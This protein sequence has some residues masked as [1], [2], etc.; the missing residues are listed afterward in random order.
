[1]TSVDSKP[2]AQ[3]LTEQVAMEFQAHQQ[4]IALAVWFDGHDL[5]QLGKLFYAQALE[6]R[7]HGMMM[8]QYQLDRDLPV[9]IPA[10]DGVRNEFGHVRELIQLALEQEKDV[11]AAI[12]RLFAAARAE[13]DYI[14]EQFV[15]WFLK[16]QVEEI[17]SMTTLLT[18]VDRA[19]DD[20]FKVEGWLA[21]EGH[22]EDHDATAPPAAGGAV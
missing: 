6:E 2:F 9:T 14:A 11:T 22:G 12:E 4:Y 5:K 21:R 1:M 18:I 13:R 17:S 10:V 7:N 16:E 8:V 20:W 3:L 19:G 15:L